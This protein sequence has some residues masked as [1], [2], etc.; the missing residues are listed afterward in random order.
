MTKRGPYVWGRRDRAA[1][2]PKFLADGAFRMALDEGPCEDS[3]QAYW[4]DA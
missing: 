3:G 2:V 4:N 1:T